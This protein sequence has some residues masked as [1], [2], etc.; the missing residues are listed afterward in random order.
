MTRFCLLTL[1][2]TPFIL[3]A[4][5][6]TKKDSNWN[7]KMVA[8]LN[9]SQS[10]FSN[11]AAGGQNTVAVTGMYDIEAI[12]KKNKISWKNGANLAYGISK[13]K[14]GPW[15]KTDDNIEVYTNVGYDIHDS[16]LDLSWLTSFRTQFDRGYNLPNDSVYVSKFM[17][18][19]YLQTALGVDYHPVDGLQILV[20]PLS[21]KFTFVNDTRLANAGAFGVT[22]AEYDTAGNVITPGKKF[23][24]ELGAFIKIL[25]STSLM[26]NISLKTRLELFSNY[27]DQPQNIDVNAEVLLNFKVNKWFQANLAVNL[28]YDDDID[29][30]VDTDGDGEINH[31]GPRTQIKEVLSLGISYTFHNRKKEK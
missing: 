24:A 31:S 18:P 25:Y 21:G 14:E 2:L 11:W 15:R 20:S 3:K 8:S 7:I 22:E 10:A 17:A 13:I 6:Q 1:L 12:Y 16:V 26:E 9:G 28:I 23:R 19:G 30:G 27:I 4:Q 29:I 5:N